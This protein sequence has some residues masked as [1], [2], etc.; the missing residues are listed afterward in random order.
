[1]RTY[2]HVPSLAFLLA[3]VAP[4]SAQTVHEVEQVGL[5]F[6]PA[7]VNIQLGDT[8]RWIWGGGNHTVTQGTDGSVDGDELFHAPLNEANPVYEVVFDEALVF[9][10]PP[11]GGSYTYFCAPHFSLKM[12][13]TIGVQ[14]VPFLG[15][16]D[17]L[18]AFFGGTQTLSLDAGP[19]AAGR[20]YL[21][22]GSASGT[23]PGIPIDGLTLPLVLDTYTLA[24]LQGAGS[25]P[26][27]GFVG[28][29]D[30]QGRGT[31]SLTVPA[32]AS[33]GLFGL[34]LNH[35]FVVLDI[36][37]FGTALSTSNAVP[38]EFGF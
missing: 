21:V 35:A 26:F 2:L 38:V 14:G 18:S 29:L 10:S 34:T 13:G 9:S 11:V 8:V 28:L 19:A 33:P 6:E 24:V 23:S 20:T 30:L 3:L 36:P 37:G 32:G 22:L 15:D 5:A 16:T 1:M 25:P 17:T 12:Q 27:A 7:D 4:L 31:A